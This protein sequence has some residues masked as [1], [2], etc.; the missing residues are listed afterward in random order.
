LIDRQ[1][2]SN[3]RSRPGLVTT[4]PGLEA[5][6]GIG[7]LTATVMVASIG[8]ARNFDNGR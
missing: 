5:I 3:S 8:D 6:P 1:E 7:P 4:R 2:S